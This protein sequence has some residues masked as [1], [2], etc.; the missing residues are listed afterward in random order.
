MKCV[1]LA[2]QLKIHLSQESEN[3]YENKTCSA[4]AGALT[5]L[6]EVFRGFPQFLQ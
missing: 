1:C 3:W 5:I 6:V 4:K 2:P